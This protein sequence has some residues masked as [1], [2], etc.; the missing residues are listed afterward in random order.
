MDVT[1][2]TLEVIKTEYPNEWIL[3][4][5]PKKKETKIIRGIV[6]FHSMDKKELAY[7]GMDLTKNFNKIT[8]IYTGRFFSK[9]R[10]GILKRFI[11]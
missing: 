7:K 1:Y 9:R 3:L 8:V 11:P 4:G 2:Q 6:L 10:I 5:N